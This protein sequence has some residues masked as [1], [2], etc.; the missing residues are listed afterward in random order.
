MDGF[1][2]RSSARQEMLTCRVC[3]AYLNQGEGFQCPRCKRSPL[4]RAHRVP[5]RRECAGCVLEIK[6]KEL[7]DLKNQEHSIRNFLRLTQFV[8]LVFAILFISS[9]AGL[10]GTVEF[11]RDSLIMENMGYLGGLSVAG[12]ILFRIIL[13]NQ[14]SRVRELET[15]MNKIEKRD[16]R[17]LVK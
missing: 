5:G 13:Y 12:Y 3:G 16:L 6:R 11:L 14:N 1:A 9:K 17:R 8:F 2:G 10:A 4:C 15:E 7:R